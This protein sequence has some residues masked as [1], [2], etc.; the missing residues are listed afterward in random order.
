M[1]TAR[2]H[3][4]ELVAAPDPS[5]RGG[6]GLTRTFGAAP[7][8]SS[9]SGSGGGAGCE[10]VDGRGCGCWGGCDALHRESFGSVVA[11]RWV[12]GREKPRGF[13]VFGAWCGCWGC[14]CVGCCGRVESFESPPLKRKDSGQPPFEQPGKRRASCVPVSGGGPPV[15]LEV[16]ETLICKAS[17]GRVSLESCSGA[18]LD[19]WVR[20]VPGVSVV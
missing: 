20:V 1:P 7:M 3:V 4:S 6:D 5:V 18:I 12:R 17:R 2:L 10:P 13:G 14:I 11:C 15:G 8:T 9:S 16:A 19:R